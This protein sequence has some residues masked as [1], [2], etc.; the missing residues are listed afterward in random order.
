MCKQGMKNG[1]L[2]KMDMLSNRSDRMHC[3]TCS[4]I[5]TI[6]EYKFSTTPTKK[7]APEDR[8]GGILDDSDE[9]IR[10][11]NFDSKYWESIEMEIRRARKKD[12]KSKG[13]L[14]KLREKQNNMM[15][16]VDKALG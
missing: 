1:K 3:G 4:Y 2:V 13:E 10:F 9:D 6:V 7:Q 5:D 8:A 12:I 11:D 15:R 14:Q 16:T